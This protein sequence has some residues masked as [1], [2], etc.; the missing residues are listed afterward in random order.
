MLAV[1]R[2]KA[3]VHPPVSALQR[4]QRTRAG[5]WVMEDGGFVLA[6]TPALSSESEACNEPNAEGLC[7]E[8]LHDLLPPCPLPCPPSSS[9]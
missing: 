3:W 1:L 2:N 6:L 4:V 7:L 9:S 5:I 8:I